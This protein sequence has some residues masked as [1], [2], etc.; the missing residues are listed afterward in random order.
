MLGKREAQSNLFG[1]DQIFRK[2]VGEESF[3]VY[4]ADHRH[5]LFR[6][7][8]FA[9]LYCKDNGRNSIPPSLLAVALLLQWY[10]D[11]SDEETARCARLDLSRKVALGIELMDIPFV[12]SVLCEFRNKLIVHKRQKQFFEATLKHARAEGF[13]KSRNI[14]VAL[15]TT[16]L[17]G[18][19]AV[20]DT[21]NMIA[22]GLR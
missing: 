21:Y 17:F 22:E 13:F 10:D 8:E 19:G 12:K 18:R 9:D 20:E 15:D 3:Y 11:V 1:C 14:K 16:P 5:E 7:E 2:L 6:D 4:L